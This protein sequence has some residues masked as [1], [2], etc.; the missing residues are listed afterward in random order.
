MT[1]IFENLERLSDDALETHLSNALAIARRRPSMVD[2]LRTILADELCEMAIEQTVRSTSLTAQQMM[3]ACLG[4]APT[5]P[6]TDTPE[7]RASDG[8]PRDII[9]LPAAR[10]EASAHTAQAYKPER[11]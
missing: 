10:G 11:Y 9:R 7:S 3:Q 5:D 8:R 6:V 1:T 4:V 2:A